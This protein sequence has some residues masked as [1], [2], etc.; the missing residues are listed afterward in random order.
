MDY[1]SLSDCKSSSASG[2]SASAPTSPTESKDSE[3][4]NND[5]FDMSGSKGRRV[6]F[7]SD[8]VIVTNYFEAPN[9]WCPIVYVSLR[10]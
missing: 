7:P 6:K 4:S 1:E 9:P 10:D 2:K 8:D 5:P 3:K